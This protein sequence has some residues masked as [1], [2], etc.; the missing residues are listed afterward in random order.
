MNNEPFNFEVWDDESLYSY[1]VRPDVRAQLAQ[2]SRTAPEK[3]ANSELGKEVRR[4]TE[5]SPFWFLQHEVQ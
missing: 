1:L 3:A 2:V 4:R 5:Q